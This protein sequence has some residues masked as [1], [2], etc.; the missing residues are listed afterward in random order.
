VRQKHGRRSHRV[1]E[2]PQYIQ[3]AAAKPQ[4]AAERHIASRQ[5]HIILSL[6]YKKQ[7]YNYNNGKKGPARPF[8]SYNP[9]NS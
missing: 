1:N 5:S 7:Q 6:P 8:F 4:R 9:Y 2:L 3:N